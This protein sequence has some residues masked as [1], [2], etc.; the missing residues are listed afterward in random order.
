MTDK[1]LRQMISDFTRL[2]LT[3]RVHY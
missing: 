1:L 2:F 3:W